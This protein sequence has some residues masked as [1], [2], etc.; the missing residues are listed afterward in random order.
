MNEWRKWCEVNGRSPAP[1][2]PSDIAA[3]I[4]DVAE[5]GIE[6]VW[7]AVK[8]IS[9]AHE[10]FGLADPTKARPVVWA[11][12]KISKIEAPRSWPDADKALFLELPLD[13]QRVVLRREAERDREVRRAHNERDIAEKELGQLRE[14]R[15][16]KSTEATSG[17]H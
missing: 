9:R 15:E 13:V 2:A 3:F 11:I 1:A 17:A 12:G 4:G 10:Q 14:I 8:D 5:L 16:T 7:A 6:K